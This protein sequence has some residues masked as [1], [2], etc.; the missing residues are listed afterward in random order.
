MELINFYNQ[1]VIT[2]N[3]VDFLNALYPDLTDFNERSVKLLRAKNLNV[4]I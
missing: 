1:I 3:I 4:L 2:P